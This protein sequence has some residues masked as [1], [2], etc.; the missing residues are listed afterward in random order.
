M[1]NTSLQQRI[2]ALQRVER[3]LL[4]EN[5]EMVNQ[6]TSLKRHH[7]ARRKRWRDQFQE[8]E[9]AFHAR[10]Q[11][12]EDRILRQD[13]ELQRQRRTSPSSVPLISDDEIVEWFSARTRA[14]EEWADEFAHQ[15][16]KRLQSGLLPVQTIELCESVKSFIQ[17]YDD[18]L[19]EELVNSD[20]DGGVKASQ[21]LLHGMLANF[22]I[23]ETLQS[24][25]WV[26]DV[27]SASGNDLES[28]SVVHANSP[29][30]FRVE[31]ALWSSVAPPRSARLP[32]KSAMLVKEPLSARR[33]PPPATAVPSLTL[34]TAG[35]SGPPPPEFPRKK[36]ME[37]FYQL[38]SNGM[39][40][41]SNPFQSTVDLLTRVSVQHN[42]REM[43]AWRAQMLQTLS[44]G[45]LSMEPENI[46]GEDRRRLA[47]ARKTHAKKLKD[48]F[49]S[50]A[51]RFL[52]K[53][54]NNLSGID[55]L[56]HRLVKEFDLALQF[57]CLVWSRH[58]PLRIKGLQEL[59]KTTFVSSDET[60]ELCESQAPAPVEPRN[61]STDMPPGYHDGHKVVMAV[62]PVIEFV[63]VVDNSNDQEISKILSKARV[64]V[65]VPGTGP[66][67]PAVII[68]HNKI[69]DDT[70]PPDSA[71]SHPLTLAAL[72]G[73]DSVPN[74]PQNNSPAFVLGM[75]RKPKSPEHV[76]DLLPEL[77][78]NTSYRG[79]R[80][81]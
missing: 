35:L 80:L 73:A 20:G 23:E 57:S 15:D 8:R 62:Q 22:I 59:A 12:L 54:E 6:M 40:G 9:K 70:T 76:P 56:E 75:P 10:I 72:G 42:N 48:R 32:P 24:P 31:L 28:P 4:A 77:L 39:C 26:F 30:G 69:P 65:A 38:L 25:F 17:L 7:E 14:W 50:G 64:L 79:P 37:N 3:D 44:E 47:D 81:P 74:F 19:P 49:L 34:H 53:E 41:S 58:D 18:G 60:M 43:H 46:K 36:E 16:P 11:A 5:H 51:A 66:R 68:E 67:K 33:L 61:E 1:E 2:A 52:L 71:G 27:L 29:I 21:I 63:S 78:P 13:E 55:Q 45:G